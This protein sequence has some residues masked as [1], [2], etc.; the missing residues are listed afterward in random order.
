ML[1]LRR[2]FMDPE[3][4]RLLA[5]A[6][7]NEMAPS[8]PFQI[9]AVETAAIPLLGALLLAAS[10]KG[11]STSGFI[12][13]KERKTTGLGRRIEGELSADPV[14]MID[15]ILN[16]GNS[17]ERA[18]QLLA[19]EGRGIEAVFVVVDFESEAGMRW[20]AAHQLKLRVL[21]TGKALGL[22]KPA[23]SHAAKESVRYVPL[24]QFAP[25]GGNA[26]HLNPKSTPLLA[27][28]FLYYGADTGT[29]WCLE[30]A[31][32]KPVWQFLAPGTINRKGIWS[33][34]R[35]HEGVI[36]FGAYNGM[37]YALDAAT[38]APRWQRLECER[39]GS[40]PVIAAENRCLVIGLEY[41]R[42]AG[43]G[44]MAAFALDGGAKLWETWLA[45][46]QH[47]SAVHWPARHLL[48]V[49]TN[50]RRVLALDARTGAIVWQYATSGEMKSAPALDAARDMVAVAGFDRSITILR[51]STGQKLFEQQTDALC[52]ATP[53]FA[54]KYLFCGSGDR[55]LYIVDVEAM[56]GVK[57]IHTRARVFATARPIGGNVIAGNCGGTVFEIGATS[58]NLEGSL[59]VPDA[60][61][62]AIA[63]S[64]DERT[65][66]VPTYMNAIY[67]FRRSVR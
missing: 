49:G 20:R 11:L 39:I 36:Y 1:D 34:P 19:A 37:L 33:S 67:A 50:D 8:L 47:G 56:R 21:Y 7:W 54:G 31:T 48:I 62:N 61:T 42:P 27:D 52:F 35:L 13:R 28:G 24:W 23:Q 46:Y 65:I 5:D 60:V 53:C 18:R 14:V 51:A 55:Y 43:R 58:L 15:D 12:I 2:L 22:P 6:F 63:V 44:S 16:S 57:R 40:S 64:E 29:L 25:P 38:G 45:D 59:T 17:L 41:E 26:F 32:G 30:A 4:L 3:A 9:G 66:Y 10:A